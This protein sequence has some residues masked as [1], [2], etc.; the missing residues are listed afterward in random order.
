MY[1]LL[2]RNI[3][4]HDIDLKDFQNSA[5]GYQL[6]IIGGKIS[7][8]RSEF[9]SIALK[10]SHKILN[11]ISRGVSTLLLV[12]S[13]HKG[14]GHFMRRF[15]KLPGSLEIGV[16]CITISCRRDK[17]SRYL[18]IVKYLLFIHIINYTALK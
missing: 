9:T 2:N 6:R 1:K 15:Q 11:A 5:C 3:S 12:P 18:L 7:L 8:K 17:N 4:L 13:T 10:S 14:R 16:N